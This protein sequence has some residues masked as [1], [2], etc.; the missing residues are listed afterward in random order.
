MAV[1]AGRVPLKLFHVCLMFIPKFIFF[2]TFAPFHSCQIFASLCIQGA[3]NLDAVVSGLNI[4]LS[5]CS[6]MSD[7][8]SD[9]FC[10]LIFPNN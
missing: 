7:S 6:M 9:V 3:S 1:A 5:S 2:V 10:M 8:C 4:C